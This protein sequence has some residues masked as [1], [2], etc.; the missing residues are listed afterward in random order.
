MRTESC[1]KCGKEM[2]ILETCN[3]CNNPSIFECKNCNIQT[4]EQFHNNCII[5]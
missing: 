4:Q 5:A 2:S 3:A 1:R